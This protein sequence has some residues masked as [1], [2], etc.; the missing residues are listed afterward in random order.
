MQAGELVLLDKREGG[1]SFSDDYDMAGAD[2]GG[3]SRSQSR[4]A[5]AFDSDLD[6]DVPF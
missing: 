1:S 5:P 6:D 3:S 4:P 2:A